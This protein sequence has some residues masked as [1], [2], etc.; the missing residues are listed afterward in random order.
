MDYPIGIQTFEKI[1]E[2][3]YVYVDKTELVYQLTQENSISIFSP[4]R[5]GLERVCSY[6]RSRVIIRGKKSFSK[7]WR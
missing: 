6:Q 7:D 4:S 3:G 1:V 5:D 2:G